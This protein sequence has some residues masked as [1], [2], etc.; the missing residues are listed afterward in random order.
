MVIFAKKLSFDRP[1]NSS[2]TIPR[3]LIVQNSSKTIPRF[4]RKYLESIS[5][6]T[7]EHTKDAKWP[8]W[9]KKTRNWQGQ[10]RND[11]NLKKGARLIELVHYGLCACW[12]QRL[13]GSKT[14][15][16]L[17][18]D[19]G[20]SFFSNFQ[21][22]F[23]ACGKDKR[24]LELSVNYSDPITSFSDKLGQ[25]TTGRRYVPPNPDDE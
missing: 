17:V 4:T 23:F 20:I 9:G 1:Q 8:E 2:K 25:E 10:E 14:Q 22:Y 24:C 11:S 13:K 19:F 7:F 21:N 6:S 18:Y 3:F 12:M 16:Y 5:I 15:K